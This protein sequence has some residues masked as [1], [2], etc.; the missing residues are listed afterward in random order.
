MKKGKKRVLV[1][2]GGKV[3]VIVMACVLAMA[4]CT[5]CGEVNSQGMPS[6]LSDRNG[7]IKTEDGTLSA[8][9]SFADMVSESTMEN[10][11]KSQLQ[12]AGKLIRSVALELETKA[13]E[14]TMA[15]LETQVRNVGGYIENMEAYNGSNYSGSTRS[16]YSHMTIR[17]PADEM[18]RFLSSVSDVGN[19]IR[20]NESAKDVTLSYVDMES[21]RDTLRTEIDRLLTFLD[22]ADSVETIIA[23]EERLSQVR[24]ELESMESKLRTIDNLV[25]YGTVNLQITEVK[26]LTPVEEKNTVGDRIVD[27]FMSNLREIWDG[28][29]EFCIW[30]VVNIPYFIIWI[31]VIGAVV[32]CWKGFRRRRRLA[33][34]KKKEAEQN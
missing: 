18:E 24:Y 23:L 22:K 20:R 5:G 8:G 32:I 13:F 26:E 25:E 2:M 30:I 3:M 17:I 31:V 27:G 1:G 9:G 28:F 4:Y 19:V 33:K 6:S 7:S 10:M 16:R 15:V 21:R 29:M 11:E 34:E 14:E 12:E